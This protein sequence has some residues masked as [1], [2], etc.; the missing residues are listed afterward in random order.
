MVKR[1]AHIL[2]IVTSL[3]A[4]PLSG[5]V[6][7][8]GPGM[9]FDKR[10]VSVLTLSLFNQRVEP[11][12][13]TSR[14][15]GDWMFR[16]ERLDLID[17][18]LRRLHPDILVAQEVMSR[19]GSP[20][21]DDIAIL[22]AGA[23]TEFDWQS[24]VVREYPDT[25]EIQSLAIGVAPP[26]RIVPPP[27]EEPDPNDPAGVDTSTSSTG[28]WLLGS[29]GYLMLAVANFDWQPLVIANVELPSEI[30][31]SPHWYTF[32]Q[33]RVMDFM[34]RRGVCPSRLVMAGQL[35]A[36]GESPQLNAMMDTL[37]LKDSSLGFCQ[38]AARCHTA[39]PQNETFMA[40]VADQSGIQA[41]R[42]YVSTDT[43][44]FQSQRAMDKGTADS[45]VAKNFGMSTLFPTQR[46]GWITEIKLARCAVDAK[47]A[48]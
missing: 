27:V 44:V 40:S 20:T 3:V 14:W 13:S 2:A 10:P 21:D 37:R 22:G 33:Q 4:T 39:T 23:L 42:V 6:T 28:L 31:T 29:D 18:D 1:R 48:P 46:F 17:T 32:I 7:L 45:A 9:E 12:T 8:F 19:R 25:D 35:P 47:V 36:T 26:L 16:R 11:T 30:A 43:I 41:D 15:S 38:V 5:C 34:S 24:E